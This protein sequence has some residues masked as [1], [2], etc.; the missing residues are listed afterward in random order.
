MPVHRLA[1]HAFVFLVYDYV[2]RIK[3][4]F[5]HPVYVARIVHHVLRREVNDAVWYSVFTCRSRL[6]PCKG[7]M[8]Y[9]RL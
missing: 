9:K 6:M 1:A 3:T 5:T 7:R 4:E 8:I 2:T